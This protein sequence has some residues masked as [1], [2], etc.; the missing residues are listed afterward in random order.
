LL[1]HRDQAG[2]VGRYREVS[3][4]VWHEPGAI[5]TMKLRQELQRKLIAE[6][7][8]KKIITFTVVHDNAIKPLDG[9]V[10]ELLN[11]H[12]KECAPY[13]K[14]AATIIPATGLKAAIVRGIIASLTLLTG[15]K[16]PTTVSATEDEAYKWIA[17]HLDAGGTTAEL[18]KIYDELR[19]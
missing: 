1:V 14:A 17:Q 8:P 11:K 6:M 2:W 15:A 13:V 10:R 16:Y 4:E 7:Q 12:I 18:S 5:N 3:I 9:D 19:K